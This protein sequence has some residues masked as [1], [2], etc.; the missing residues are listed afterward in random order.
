MA[1]ICKCTFSHNRGNDYTK[2]APV[3]HCSAN[4]QTKDEKK[5]NIEKYKANSKKCLLIPAG[6]RANTLNTIEPSSTTTTKYNKK[7][8]NQ[9]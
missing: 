9:Q 7:Q 3:I 1:K 6:A 5:K 2:S 8:K 4:Q